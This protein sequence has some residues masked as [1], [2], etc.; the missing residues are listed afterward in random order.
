M[1]LVSKISSLCVLSKDF[2]GC[3][4]VF[5]YIYFL[6]QANEDA[7][8]ALHLAL[9]EYRNSGTLATVICAIMD[10]MKAAMENDDFSFVDAI[11]DIILNN[12]MCK[13]ILFKTTKGSNYI[14]QQ[15]NSFN[16]CLFCI[17][18]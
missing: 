3:I 17:I 2:K 11:I 10:A 6:L 13:L 16:Q 9:N 1:E 4:L 5:E 18:T 12:R 15:R 14:Y 7:N 8:N